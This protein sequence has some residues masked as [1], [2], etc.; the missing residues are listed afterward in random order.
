MLRKSWPI[1]TIRFART[2][3]QQTD[4]TCITV[5][6]NWRALHGRS[7]FTGK[8][9]MCGGYSKSAMFSE[10]ISQVLCSADQR[11]VPVSRDDFISKYR[12]TNLGKEEIAAST[13]TG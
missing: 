6:D 4:L 13:V 12:M 1:P 10:Q 5:F 8:R 9:R 3:R 11:C 2:N 7:S